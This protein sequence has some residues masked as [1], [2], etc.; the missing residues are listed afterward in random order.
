M[1][2]AMANG[3]EDRLI[4][5][6]SFKLAPGA[7]YI[8][9][10][11]SVTYHPQGSNIYS[12]Q[13][14]TKLIR[15]AITGDHWLD[16]STFRIMFDVVTADTDATRRLR[17]LLAPWAFF[18]RLRVLAGG[19]LV[20]DID[21]YN[22]VHHM[23]QNMI[24]MDSATNNQ[25]EGFG[26]PDSEPRNLP[27][28]YQLTGIAGNSSQT[29]L[30]KPLCGLL[31]Q[32]K[33]LPIRYMPLT[34]ELELATNYLDPIVDPAFDI[35]DDFPTTN[36]STSWRIENVMA[37]MDMCTLDNALDNSYAQH[38][39]SGRS[40]PIHYDTWVSQFEAISRQAPIVNITRALTRL[41][42]VFVTFDKDST[43]AKRV[44]FFRKQWND[45][46][47]PACLDSITTAAGTVYGNHN[48]SFV[49]NKTSELEIQLQVGSKL[50][51]EY[52]IRTHS[53]AY[54]QLQKALGVQSSN[55]HNFNINGVEY[56][57]NKFIVGFDTEKVIEAGWTG[58]NTR[59]G[60]LL[61][62][63]MKYDPYCPT[64]R[65]ADRIHIILH[66]DQILEIR[67][68]GCQVFD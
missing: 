31:S 55:L 8:T 42:S 17:P 29:V 57:D 3:I 9:D 62:V 12:S 49:F 2:E 44:K 35:A 68:S 22:R 52:P 41:K 32:N 36:T 43:D 56:R 48:G 47:S 58:M 4:D 19:Q 5:G 27:N 11:R 37:K 34:L 30:F 28:S 64:T 40:L 14:G 60:D 1:V 20:E 10:R 65:Q 15:I 26:Y 61:T 21:Y 46:Y 6:L 67:D 39:L 16:P 54:Y 13:S 45:F 63:K 24:S 18:R 51:P 25:A 53:E 59:S 66:S 33:Y 38:L 23:F 7:S 50:F